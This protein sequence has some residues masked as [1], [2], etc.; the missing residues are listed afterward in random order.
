MGEATL[1]DTC[2]YMGEAT[3]VST[4]ISLAK[5]GGY[6]EF[7]NFLQKSLNTKMLVSR[8]LCEIERFWQNF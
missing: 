1:P 8:K 7:S 3:Q 5:N 6:F 4:N 2:L